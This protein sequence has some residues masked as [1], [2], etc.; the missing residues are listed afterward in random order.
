MC[1]SSAFCNPAFLK[2][3]SIS[4]F[5]TS[6][7]SCFPTSVDHPRRA[8]ITCCSTF[9]PSAFGCPIS[10]HWLSFS[11]HGTAFTNFHGSLDFTLMTDSEPVLFD[12]SV[13]GT[14]RNISELLSNIFG[15]QFTC[16]CTN[17]F[18]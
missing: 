18:F 17:N 6:P 11:T 2:R 13:R 1:K 16:F 12:R 5:F 7:A 4:I 10:P 15:L 9:S 14:L 3:K 8:S